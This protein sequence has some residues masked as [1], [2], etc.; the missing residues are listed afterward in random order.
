MLHVEAIPSTEL[1]GG[2]EGVSCTVAIS[3]KFEFF[4]KT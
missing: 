1:I 3:A 2:E 4:Q